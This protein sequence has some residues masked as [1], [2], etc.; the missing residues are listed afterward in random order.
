MRLTQY[1]EGN[2]FGVFKF[3]NTPLFNK[4]FNG[5]RAGYGVAVEDLNTFLSKLFN[6]GSINID[7]NNRGILNIDGSGTL[8]N[9][10]I[11]LNEGYVKMSSGKFSLE[12]EFG[13]TILVLGK[14]CSSE[15]ES[16]IAKIR[17]YCNTYKG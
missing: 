11:D 6:V 16:Y 4:M 12:G 14:L 13:G 10:T 17:N 1:F 8:P 3:E 2:S 15:A 9:I 7:V 5:G